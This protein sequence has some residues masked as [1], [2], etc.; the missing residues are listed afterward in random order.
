MKRILV[1]TLFAFILFVSIANADSAIK[2]PF[3]YV[4][5]YNNT[6]IGDRYFYAVFLNCSIAPQVEYY[7]FP[8]ATNYD[9]QHIKISK[10]NITQ[11][12]AVRN[13][14]WAPSLQCY[15]GN[16]QWNYGCM[17]S[18][19]TLMYP[20][21]TNAK[22]AIY[23]PSLNK[24]FISDEIFNESFEYSYH[25]AV[26]LQNGTIELSTIAP[27]FQIPEIFTSFITALII[28]LVTELLV[29]FL[30]IRFSKN[31]DFSQKQNR[32]LLTVVL[33]NIISLP[34]VWFVLPLIFTDTITYY[35]VAESFAVLFEGLFI[36]LLNKNTFTLKNALILSLIMNLASF[37]VGQ[38]LYAI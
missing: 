22:L 12:D 10:P 13:C 25:E 35:V 26:L 4:K 18:E 8:N 32:I 19:C 36:R 21:P 34:V 11:Y 7:T 2:L 31:K 24:V 15:Q 14:T 23:I 27:P 17:G 9:I 29:T 28:T 1:T 16:C 5:Y 6:N 38:F 37:F 3:I 30:F 33:V 20:P